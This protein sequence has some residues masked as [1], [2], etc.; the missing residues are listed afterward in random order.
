MFVKKTSLI[1]NS[2]LQQIKIN[3][4]ASLE[5]IYNQYWSKLYIYAFNILREREICEDIVQEIFI[6]LWAKRH[7]VKIYDLNSYLYQAVK[8]Q[9]FNHFR[10]SKYKKQ[11]LMKLNLINS[12]YKIDDLF[13][14]KELKAHINKAISRLPK[15]RRIIFQMSRYEGLSNKEIS[16]NLNISLQTVKNQISASLKFI[17]K[18]LNN[19]YILFF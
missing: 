13:E 9:V 4:R 16:E 18:S 7:K 10:K 5:K 8:Y 14:K 3:D 11:L 19:L 6:D 1:D 17:R 2:P 12:E 15:Q